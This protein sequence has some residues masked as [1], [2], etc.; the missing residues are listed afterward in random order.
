MPLRL[1]YS[2]A[3]STPPITDMTSFSRVSDPVRSAHGEILGDGEDTQ[4][5]ADLAEID[6][7][8]IRGEDQ[9]SVT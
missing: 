2:D 4:K 6:V 7:P 8:A 3:G 1:P 5:T 9:P